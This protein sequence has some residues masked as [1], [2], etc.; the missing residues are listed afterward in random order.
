MEIPA[1]KMNPARDM[2]ICLLTHSQVHQMVS[3][4][5]AF[6]VTWSQYI[7]NKLEILRY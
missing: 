5:S 2:K 7:C 3:P 6:P 4:T 1:L